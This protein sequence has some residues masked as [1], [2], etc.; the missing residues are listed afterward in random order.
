MW[1]ANTWANLKEANLSSAAVELWQ[2]WALHRL[3]YLRKKPAEKSI[4]PQKTSLVPRVICVVLNQNVKLVSKNYWTWKP[5]FTLAN[6]LKQQEYIRSV[7]AMVLALTLC[8]V[9]VFSIEPW[10]NSLK[11]IS[12]SLLVQSLLKA[13][14][15]LC[16]NRLKKLSEGLVIHSDHNGVEHVWCIPP[17]KLVHAHWDSSAN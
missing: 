12:G 2:Q 6:N 15:L 8:A 4:L 17:R 5:M 7:S 14:L 1:C 10:N 9:S 16:Q 11:G 13:G 3:I